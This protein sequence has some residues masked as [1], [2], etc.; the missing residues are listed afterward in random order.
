MLSG[1][2]PSWSAAKGTCAPAES[3]AWRSGAACCSWTSSWRL[4]GWRARGKRRP[5]GDPRRAP[6]ARRAKGLSARRAQ[7]GC[8]PRRRSSSTSEATGAGSSPGARRASLP[9]TRAARLFCL[10]YPR[11]GRR[12]AL[13]PPE[14]TSRGSR[15][16]LP[17]ARTCASSFDGL[18]WSLPSSSSSFLRSASLAP[19]P[20][21]PPPPRPLSCIAELTSKQESAE[22]TKGQGN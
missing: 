5:G 9:A 16:V 17:L 1:W 22:R 6:P 20:P 2:L 7:P 18:A 19:P 15:P 4:G 13:L 10:L 21:P 8:R 3:G 11:A 14:P 12:C